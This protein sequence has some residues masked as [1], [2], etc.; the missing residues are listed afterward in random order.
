MNSL[1]T[2][3]YIYVH[4]HIYIKYNCGFK[5]IINKYGV[6]VLKEVGLRT[7]FPDVSE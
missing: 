7:E 5:L 6:S 2:Y 4:V 1:R 3:T